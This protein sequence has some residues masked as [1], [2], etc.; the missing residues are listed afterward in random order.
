MI[1]FAGVDLDAAGRSALRVA[2]LSWSEAVGA[3]GLEGAEPDL[4]QR[5]QQ[6]EHTA[7]RCR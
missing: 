4:P 6:G 5:Q 3:V 1:F 2:A 7:V